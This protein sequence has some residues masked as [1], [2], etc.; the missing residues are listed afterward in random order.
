MSLHLLTTCP[1]FMCPEGYNT[2][3][4]KFGTDSFLVNGPYSAIMA[5]FTPP[6]GGDGGYWGFNFP[7]FSSDN[8]GPMTTTL[9][10]TAAL[11][12]ALAQA[13]PQQQNYAAPY[14]SQT[15]TP[16]TGP[17]TDTLISLYPMYSYVSF[18]IMY[19]WLTIGI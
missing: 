13:P 5:A 6:E 7:G 8:E 11:A 12:Q 15:I 14:Y 4:R 2:L 16:M 19:S 9:P 3:R 17:S 1:C 18:Q 10:S